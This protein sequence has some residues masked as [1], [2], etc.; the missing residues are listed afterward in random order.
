MNVRLMAGV[1]V[2]VVTSIMLAPYIARRLRIVRPAAYLAAL[3][4]MM[5]VAVTILERAEGLPGFD[6]GT[7]LTWWTTLRQSPLEVA[8]TEAA[9]WL[10]LALFVPAGVV[11]AAVTRRPFAVA[12]ALSGFSIGIETVQGLTGLG[13][14]DLTDVVA[15]S[16]GG[17]IGVTVVALAL[18]A[19]PHLVPSFIRVEAGADEQRFDPK[20]ILGS[21]VATVLAIGA[22]FGGVEGALA[23]RQR[24]LRE[25]VEATYEGMTVGDINAILEQDTIGLNPF[26]VLEAGSPDSY[27][28]YGD[29]RPVEV[30]Y[31]I[32]LLGRY[33][34]VFV[35]L[36]DAPPV[37]ANASGKECTEDRYPE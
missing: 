4:V 22:G 34:C 12:V 21:F 9:W 33:R 20:W 30:R 27:R 23:A 16:L 8:R 19:S 36:S 2:A 17:V 32:D 26:L 14:A 5:I 11:W 18:G 37:F 25:E 3:T 29:D 6:V 10:N 1:A 15:N 13:A 31:P 28:F 24:T 35:T 7:A